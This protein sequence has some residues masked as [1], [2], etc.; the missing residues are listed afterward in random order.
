M[1]NWKP[2]FAYYSC[3]DQKACSG[4]FVSSCACGGEFCSPESHEKSSNV[5][6][7]EDIRQHLIFEDHPSKFLSYVTTFEQQCLA[8]YIS[9]KYVE[10]C[11]TS[12]MQN[13]DLPEDDINNKIDFFLSSCDARDGESIYQLYQDLTIDR[14]KYRQIGHYPTVILNHQQLDFKNKNE[15]KSLLCRKLSLEQ[16]NGCVTITESTTVL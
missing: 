7:R 2:R 8:N 11:S 3:S 12:I 9:T 1:V 15:L 5:L 6:V 14:N 16:A 13:L 4:E 10:D